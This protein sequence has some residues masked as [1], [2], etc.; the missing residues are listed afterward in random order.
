MDSDQFEMKVDFF[1]KNYFESGPQTNK[2]LYQNYRWIPE[3]TIPLGF[4]RKS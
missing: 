2:S 4:G 1:D 3:L